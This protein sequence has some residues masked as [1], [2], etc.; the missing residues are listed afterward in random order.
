LLPAATQNGHIEV[1]AGHVRLRV[2]LEEFRVATQNLGGNRLVYF[3]PEFTETSTVKRM[4]AF[5][6]GGCNPVVFGFERG[7]YNLG[8]KPDWPHVLLGRTRDGRYLQRVL[9]LLGAFPVLWRERHILRNAAIFYARNF[10]QLLLALVVALLFNRSAVMVYE[11]LDIQPVMVRRGLRSALIRFAE[12]LCLRRVAL[13]VVSSPAFFRNY[14]R[15]RQRYR[16][17][18]F[19][20][21]N[22]LHGSVHDVAEAVEAKLTPRR[23]NP[24]GRWVVGY[25]GLIRGKATVD[26]MLRVAAALEDK[27][28]FYFRG[29]LTTVDDREFGAALRDAKNVIYGGEYANPRDLPA[30]YDAVDFAW[31]LDLENVADNSRWLLPCRFYEAGLYGVPCLAVR[32]FELGRRLDA[33]DIGWT[34]SEPLE[35]ALV[36]FFETLTIE[37]YAKKRARLTK[38]P[39]STFVAADDNRAF[40]RRLLELAEAPMRRRAPATLDTAGTEAEVECRPDLPVALD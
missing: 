3:A 21:E 2:S 34:F 33:L 10:D 27:V 23:R 28:V 15:E 32:D 25:F 24:E 39:H 18:W 19:L 4:H 20:L 16:G 30:L 6:D 22:K 9:A 12:R 26:L 31:A 35:K 7:R 11:I 1:E 13:L 14:Y 38:L 5:I 40:C 36:T 29:V 8:F 37:A 17:D